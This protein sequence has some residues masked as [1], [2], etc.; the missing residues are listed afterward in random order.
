MKKRLFAVL[1]SMAMLAGTA[2]QMPVSAADD[3]TFWE[4][5]VYSDYEG[6]TAS[7]TVTLRIAKWQ[8][9]DLLT[10]LA[11]QKE[12]IGE[13]SD[14]FNQAFTELLL[15]KLGLTELYEYAGSEIIGVTNPS[16]WV[17]APD[18]FKVL[19]DPGDGGSICTVSVQVHKAFSVKV[20][21]NTVAQTAK[22]A[23]RRILTY[24]NQYGD[25]AFFCTAS[26]A[27]NDPVWDEE[28]WDRFL[29]YDL[30]IADFEALPAEEQALAGFIF[31]TEQSS[32]QTVRCERARRTLAHDP[33]IGERITLEQAKDCYGICDWYYESDFSSHVCLH[34][35][36]DLM[37]MD[38]YGNHNDYWLD[39]TGTEYIKEQ[40]VYGNYNE[41][42]DS[43]FYI[44]ANSTVEEIP[45][46]KKLSYLSEYS[47]DGTHLLR[48]DLEAYPDYVEE[49]GD[50]YYIT[51][52]K[53]AVLVLSRYQNQY[54]SRDEI[55]K[56][57]LITEP[58]I[59]PDTVQGCP[60][61]AIDTGAF[62]NAKITEVQLPE[63]VQYIHYGA[64]SE[65]QFLSKINFPKDI[66]LIGCGAF[67]GAALTELELDAPALRISDSAFID[68]R[69]LER[70]EM[71][72]KSIGEGAF[73]RCVALKTIKLGNAVQKIEANAFK[74]SGLSEINIP[75]SVEIIGTE[76]FSADPPITI[77]L[78]PEPYTIVYDSLPAITLPRT[79]RV[80]GALAKQQGSP[81]TSGIYYPPVLPLTEDPVCVFG[82]N[83][84][85]SGYIGTEAERYAKEWGLQFIAMDFISGDLNGDGIVTV[86]DA[87]LL[88]RV[89][90]EDI[91][92]SVTEEGMRN[93]D[94]NGSGTPD[95]DD[96]TLI[97]KQIA[98]IKD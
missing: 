36:P 61:V 35:V 75:E 77:S 88:A 92:V 34:C 65:C 24:I 55:E 70:A 81:P 27:S 50:Y 38:D 79:V 58:V 63:T 47:D 51:P 42:R 8:L 74:N 73:L 68:C 14:K 13:D 94:M 95:S 85:I 21:E 86:S 83:C 93:A 98:G 1:C 2:I 71:N 12:A 31:A 10:E 48:I 49:D 80:L 72:V 41:L 30:C 54:Q 17:E 64:F 15:E 28:L 46:K 26:M 56:Q 32:T 23:A 43:M 20:N 84:V 25:K 40:G 97:L 5:F 45:R 19:D 53:T 52:E 4:N 60:V 76:A 7:N 9:K 6:Y 87:I 44:K 18:F 90:A 22:D 66:R 62:Q 78:P 37:Y 16:K 39:D 3:S 33:D 96:L 11:P 89:L 67:V 69:N 29:K 59:V 57:E 82:E 91:T